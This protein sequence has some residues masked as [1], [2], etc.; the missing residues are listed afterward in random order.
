MVERL[1]EF[2]TNGETSILLGILTVTQGGSLKHVWINVAGG[3]IDYWGEWPQFDYEEFSVSDD[4]WGFIMVG[5]LETTLNS[6]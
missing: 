5:K 4:D 2:S 3:A 6:Q 1:E